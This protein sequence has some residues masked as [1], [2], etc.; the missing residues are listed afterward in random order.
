MNVYGIKD[1]KEEIIIKD[2]IWKI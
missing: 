2:G 1:G